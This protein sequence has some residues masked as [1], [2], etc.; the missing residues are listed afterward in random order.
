MSLNVLSFKQA[1][2]PGQ[3][4]NSLV[5]RQTLSTGESVTDYSLVIRSLIHFS[6]LLGAQW[7]PVIL[8]PASVSFSKTT[9]L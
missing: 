2:R 1:W 4:Q 8:R 5:F 3:Q 7:N 6:C 9:F